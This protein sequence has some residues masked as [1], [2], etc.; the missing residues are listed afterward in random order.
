[1]HLQLKLDIFTRVLPGQTLSQVPIMV[2]DHG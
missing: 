2:D 1:M